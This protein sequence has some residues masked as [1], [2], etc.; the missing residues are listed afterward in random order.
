MPDGVD[1]Q[2]ASTKEPPDAPRQRPRALSL[3]QKGLLVVGV[4]VAF[5]VILLLSLFAIEQ[6]HDRDREENRRSKEVIASG[7]RLL[8]L[9]VDAETGMR[10]YALTGNPVF[11]QPYDWAI[12]QFPAELEHL[13]ALTALT[14]E[15]SDE[16]HVAELEKLARPVLDYHRSSIEKI[17]AGH[18]DE[19][20]VSSSRQVGKQL[21]DRFRDAMDRF[22]AE[23][24]LLD[25]ERE[26]AAR[27]A[28]N[29][30][31]IAFAG[32]GVLNI[33]LAGFLAV[34]FTRNI[35]R[36]VGVVVTNME[37]LERSEP[38]QDP[39]E[40]RDDIAEI[41]RRFHQMAAALEQAQKELERFFTVSLDML[42]IAG[43]DGFFKRMNPAW[44]KTLGYSTAELC[45]RPFIDFVHPDDRQA[46]VTE[47]Q[48]LGEG[49]KTISF[50]NRYRHANGS[51]RWLLWNAAAVPEVGIIYAAATDITE[52]KEFEG[53]L[54]DQNAALESANRELESF[55]Y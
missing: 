4:P 50:E 20:V 42:C 16:L 40:G 54:E 28:G 5:Q 29:E 51:Y 18:R 13:R 45:S 39:I 17:R 2:P 22:L 38:L 8:G 3:S 43:F 26:R 44:E 47:A 10:G 15:K 1:L 25:A 6:A 49:F 12:V 41:D 11:T 35:A 7:Y 48:R 36:R 30:I 31:I 34:F 9:V 21:M 53:T 23:E 52:R 55:Y 27:R 32:G 24:R 14:P 37:R 46:T 19:V 33:A